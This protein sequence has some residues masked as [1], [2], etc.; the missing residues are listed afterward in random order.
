MSLDS[1]LSTVRTN[2]CLGGPLSTAGSLYAD[3]AGTGHDLTGMMSAASARMQMLQGQGVIEGRLATLMLSET[4]VTTAISR[5]LRR[6]DEWRVASGQYAG[7]W[8]VE[9]TNLVR[10]GWERADLRWERLADA[11]GAQ[12]Q[13]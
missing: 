1:L 3:G 5:R 6:G 12:E 8:R 9:D 10:G 11:N 2:A 13:R 4:D 7:T